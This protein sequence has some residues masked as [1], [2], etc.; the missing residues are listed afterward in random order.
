MKLKHVRSGK[1][2]NMHNL[3]LFLAQD[4]GTAEDAYAG[5]IIG[6]PSHG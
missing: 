6:M 5:D 3:V 1:R 2:I 4:R